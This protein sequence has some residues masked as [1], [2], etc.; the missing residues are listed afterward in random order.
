[1]SDTDTDTNEPQT[2]MAGPADP[3]LDAPAQD[4]DAVTD[5]D[6]A[7]AEAGAE[8]GDASEAAEAPDETVAAPADPVAEAGAVADEAPAEAAAD[9]EAGDGAAEA[10]VDEA[11]EVEAEPA[12]SGQAA[13]AELA[14]AAEAEV[15][16]DEE[17][18]ER[19]PAES[20][21]D[22]PGRWFVVHTQSGYE[23][24]VKQNLEARIVSMNAE[25]AIYEVVIP[26]EDYVD[27]RNGKRIVAQRK[28]FPG[29][30]LVRA[31][32]DDQA[33]FVIRN[34]PGVTGFVGQGAK[35]SPLPRRD[36]ES[37]L[38][39]KGGTEEQVAQR[40]KPRLEYEIGETVRVREGPF[41]DFSGEVIEL[42]EDQLKLKVLVNIFGRETPVELEFSKVAK[43]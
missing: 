14:E 40:A 18:L 32:L 13:A 1:M 19:P 26:M 7:A 42:N 10:A 41:A 24:K 20:P 5:D 31:A 34:T 6:G 33:W 21:Y 11:T 12:A 25:D 36:V 22:R 39:P 9:D 2:D 23:K 8:A 35:P 3:A 30:L 43:L 28:M 29:Y 17:L 38:M 37:F 15:I 27:F 16:T 4:A